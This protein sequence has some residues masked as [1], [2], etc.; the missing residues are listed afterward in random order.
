MDGIIFVV[1]AVVGGAILVGAI[2]YFR[3][4]KVMAVAEEL[5][6]EFQ[7]TCNLHNQLKGCE[8]FSHRGHSEKSV[9]CFGGA[10]GGVHFAIFEYQYSLGYG[11]QRR[12]HSQ[13]VCYIDVK[14][15]DIPD[16]SVQNKSFFNKMFSSAPA[17]NIEVSPDFTERFFL[18]CLEPRRVRPL[19]NEEVRRMMLL[20]SQSVECDKGR[21]LTYR[22]GKTVS[23]A[24]LKDFLKE[25]LE[26][27]LALNAANNCDSAEQHGLPL[28]AGRNATDQT[29]MFDPQINM[30]Y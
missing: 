25:G 6:L 22:S 14:Q 19:F 10:A 26:L 20:N 30:Q 11:K 16:F 3:R 24:D 21:L 4:K 2:N 29:A 17:N 13:T 7:P 23:H 15:H 12:Q 5:G 8:L 27:M 1:I 18:T 9:N 28:V